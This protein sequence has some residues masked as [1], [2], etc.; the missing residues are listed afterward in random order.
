MRA[1]GTIISVYDGMDPLSAIQCGFLD[2]YDHWTRIDPRFARHHD[3]LSPASGAFGHDL[4]NQ[5]TYVHEILSRLPPVANN[6]RG[7][8]VTVSSL[9]E[10]FL[11]SIRSA[12][13]AVAAGLGYVSATKLGQ[14]PV[15]SIFDLHKWAKRN[16]TRVRC[17][18]INAIESLPQ[19]FF[20]LRSIR[21]LVIHQGADLT[22]H[23]DTRQFN[24]WVYGP[25]GWVTREPLLPFLSRHLGDLI[26]FAN[27]A[28]ATINELIEFPKDRVGC[29]AVEGVYVSSL[30]RLRDIQGDYA[31]ASP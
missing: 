17:E 18:A 13:D 6:D 21:D 12:Y 16:R 24:L 7:T 25:M 23:C 8:V 22:I 4:V 27:N 1:L 5:A 10:A 11:V 19:S 28:S 3:A 2:Y 20:E 9:T 14:A 29:R 30:H 15:A 26:G 31:N